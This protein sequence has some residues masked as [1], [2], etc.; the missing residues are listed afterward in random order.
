MS[1]LADMLITAAALSA[2]AALALVSLPKAPAPLRLTIAL[3]GL[4]A[5]L[6]PWP[7]IRLPIALPDAFEAR[8][9]PIAASVSWLYPAAPGAGLPAAGWLGLLA[10]VIAV[11]VLWFAADCAA[12][13]ASLA[14][15]RSRS[16]DG[17]ELRVLLPPA[18]R[19]TRVT[20][21]VIG[22]SRA[23]AA[24]GPL[25][26]T[27]WIG[28]GFADPEDARVALVHECWH[29]RRNDPF[30]IAA[31]TLVKRVY[32]WNPL[33][34]YLAAHAL[35]LVEAACDRRCAASLG[36]PH[37]IERLAAMMLDS[38]CRPSP[39]LAAAARGHNVTRLELLSAGSRLRARDLVWLL[40]L[41]AVGTGFA[42]WRVADAHVRA[43]VASPPWSRVAIPG[44]P[45]GRALEALLDLDAWASGLELVEIVSSAPL[46]IEYIVENTVD[47]TRRQ[48][49]LE[50]ADGPSLKVTAAALRDVATQAR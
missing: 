32:W 10:A 18:L 15:W 19:R 45:A 50:V 48:G 17:E 35:L 38:A 14:A 42:G 6:V 33:V 7:W 47:A 39:R 28:D 29:V 16:R 4:A 27:I 22:G 43:P 9:E 21:R 30:L 2:V 31:I 46:R 20:I 13:R 34:A 26:P 23:A 41:A 3:A 40:A 12:L 1:A 37:Y 49:T 24:T 8:L 5:W 25:N 44:T 36:I 11:G